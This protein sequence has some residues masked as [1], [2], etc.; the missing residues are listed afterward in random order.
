M[1]NR[2]FEE[3]TI[4]R[5]SLFAFCFAN[6]TCCCV[7]NITIQGEY[8]FILTFFS[9]LNQMRYKQFDWLEQGVVCCVDCVD[10]HNMIHIYFF[11]KLMGNCFLGFVLY[12]KN[13][14]YC[15]LQESGTRNHFIKGCKIFRLHFKSISQVKIY[16]IYN[17]LFVHRRSL[18][19]HQDLNLSR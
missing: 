13:R 16:Y 1:H 8:F 6:F 17:N 10:A 7:Q 3:V 11:S 18:K 9:N 15:I 5:S 14:S 12:V 2:F 4:L 19:M